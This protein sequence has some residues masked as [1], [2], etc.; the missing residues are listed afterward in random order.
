M[1]ALKHENVMDTLYKNILSPN[2]EDNK[3][4]C[5]SQVLFSNTD[6]ALEDGNQ[7]VSRLF[8][9]LPAARG[10]FT[11]EEPALC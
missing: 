2:C 1:C 9:H 7:T 5:G 8:H 3:I 11:W 6:P 10:I 4:E